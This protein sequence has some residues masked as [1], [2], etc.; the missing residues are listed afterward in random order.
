MSGCIRVYKRSWRKCY[1]I[2]TWQVYVYSSGSECTR[3]LNVPELRRFL[4][5]HDCEYSSDS[6]YVWVL[7]MQGLHKI[8]NKTLHG[9]YLLGFWIWPSKY[10]T[11][12]LVT[13]LQRVLC[14]MYSRDLWYSEHASGFQYTKILNALGILIC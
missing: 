7:N 11:P 14:N 9:R 2:N 5:K 10:N 3:I 4:K 1:I 8:L 6:K 12:L 13:V